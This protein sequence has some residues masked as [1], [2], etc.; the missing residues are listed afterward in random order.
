[1]FWFQPF[2]KPGKKIAKQRDW[3]KKINEIVEKAPEWDISFLVGV[4]AWIQMCVEMIL[5]R[6]KLSHIHEIWPNLS[7][8][9]HGG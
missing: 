9:V 4:P 5:E 8:F 3:N 6:Y 2:Y 1:P 7:F